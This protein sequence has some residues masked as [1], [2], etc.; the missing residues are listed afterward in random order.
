MAEISLQ[1]LHPS[2]KARNLVLTHLSW[3]LNMLHA[4]IPR[5]HFP[6]LVLSYLK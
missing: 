5:K 1:V 4:A 3:Q 6:Q 2:R